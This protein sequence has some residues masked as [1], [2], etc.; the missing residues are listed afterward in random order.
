MLDTSMS[1]FATTS[2][3]DQ[4]GASMLSTVQ[5]R[6]CFTTKLRMVEH[7]GARHIHFMPL[8]DGTSIPLPTVIVLS[9]NVD[10]LGHPVTKSLS[11]AFG[12][13][14]Q[15]FE[16]LVA[17]R[18]PEVL[19]RI[20]ICLRLLE[21]CSLKFS[22]DDNHPGLAAML[23]SIEFLVASIETRSIDIEQ[24]GHRHEKLLRRLRKQ[25]NGFNNSPRLRDHLDRLQVILGDA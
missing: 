3:N 9:R 1:R 14:P 6:K 13:H 2:L 22:P 12:M 7:Q 21:F 25:V 19:W 4:V 18:I 24:E 10:D 11:S 17:C 20:C 5:A 23:V 8:I 15:E 16:E